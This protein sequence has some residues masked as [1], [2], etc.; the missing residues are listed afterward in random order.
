[1]ASSNTAISP[2]H[3]EKH[4]T[5]LICGTSDHCS[6]STPQIL[7]SGL[8]QYC[9]VARGPRAWTTPTHRCVVRHVCIANI[10]RVQIEQNS[11]ARVI[12]QPVQPNYVSRMILAS[13]S[14]TRQ[15]QTGMFFYCKCAKLRLTGI[16]TSTGLRKV[17]E[18][19][20]SKWL[21]RRMDEFIHNCIASVTQLHW[22]TAAKY[23]I[24]LQNGKVTFEIS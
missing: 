12:T 6:H 3:L 18:N 16:F 10:H 24:D 4:A 21:K 11:L 17:P 7:K 15:L 2:L 9:V 14:P 23:S 8:T 1:M 22:E 19:K 20:I 13:S 5:W